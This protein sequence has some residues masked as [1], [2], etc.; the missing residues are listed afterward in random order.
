MIIDD[1]YPLPNA[2]DFNSRILG[3][4]M[5]S[6]SDLQKGYYQVPMASE[7]IQKTAMV[8]P[9]GMFKF[10]RMPFGLRNAGNTFQHMMDLVLGELSFC[11][12]YMDNILIFSKDLSSHMD[13]LQEV[14]CLYRRH[15]LTIGLPK[16]ELP[17]SKIEIIGCSLLTKHSAAISTMSFSAEQQV[18]WLL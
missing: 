10:L 3:M 7:D 1:Q 9:F 17:V 5:F 13:N 11:Y 4:T 15:D 18:S 2:A 8:T 14:F 12:V 16:C 6:K